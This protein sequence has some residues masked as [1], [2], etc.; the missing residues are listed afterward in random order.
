LGK[1]SV[2]VAIAVVLT[3]FATAAA[4]QLACVTYWSAAAVFVG[5]VEAVKRDGANRTISFVVVESLRGVS[6]SAVDA[7]LV[8]PR[9]EHCLSFAVGGEFF[10]YAERRPEGGLVVNG[11]GRSR[12]IEDASADLEYARSVRQGTAPVGS[13]SGNVV[14]GYRTLAGKSVARVRTAPV[15]KVNLHK[16]GIA[17]AATTTAGSG[18]YQLQSPDAGRYR[19]T[20]DIPEGLYADQSSQELYLPDARACADVGLEL[21]DNGRVDG[22]VIDVKGRPIAGL[23][24][25]IRSLG[26]AGSLR[27][28]TDRD[29]RYAF[30]KLPAGRFAV[31]VPG[32]RSP[33]GRSALYFPGVESATATT[34]I[35][36]AEGERKPLADFTIPAHRSYVAVSGIV[37]DAGGAPAEGARVFLK[38]VGDDDRIVSEPVTAD[39]MGRFVIAA[40]AGIE[41]GLF[42]ERARPGSRAGGVDATDTLRLTAT[43]GLALVRLVLERRY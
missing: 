32:G 6:S 14:V 23:T 3:A 1:L 25:E 2:T 11:C 7:V 37:L 4:A 10:I 34:R 24:L 19:V 35:T 5:R 41:Y 9:R 16:D 36:L 8:L 20:F 12:R 27:T 43:D 29:G 39:F 15:I 38:N 18:W 42:A 40:R 28:V 30:A 26:N 31:R 13:V 33:D 17:V 21:Y 22:R